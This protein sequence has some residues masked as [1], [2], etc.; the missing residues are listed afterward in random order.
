VV[1]TFIPRR[2]RTHG[3]FTAGDPWN[4]N[5][6]TEFSIEEYVIMPES[7][8]HAVDSVQFA[9][10]MG[11]RS[12]SDGSQRYLPESLIELWRRGLVPA[13]RIPALAQ[14]IEQRVIKEDYNLVLH[15]TPMNAV[16]I[17]V[18][19]VFAIVAVLAAVIPFQGE[20][21]PIAGA[22]AIG[23]AMS[24][25]VGGIMWMVR[26]SARGRR[27]QQMKWLLAVHNGT[28]EAPPE[29]AAIASLK[30]FGKIVAMLL[31]FFLVLGGGAALWFQYGSGA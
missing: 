13:E 27:K 22:V 3:N 19:F 20:R 4:G 21:L 10:R 9:H 7:S 15:Q 6:P 30:M 16:V 29:G 26:Q 2:L 31:L 12:E 5:L 24:L 23:A 1:I 25:F 18:A 14:A 8:P 17:P 11:L 28:H